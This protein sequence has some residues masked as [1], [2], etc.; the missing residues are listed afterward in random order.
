MFRA[1]SLYMLL[2]AF[3]MTPFPVEVLPG[4]AKAAAP[5]N[6][7]PDGKLIALTFDDGPKPYVLLGTR[8]GRVCP[9][10]VCS[11]CWIDK[12]SRRLSS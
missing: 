3:A 10:R 7:A 9:P 8:S 6:A 5:A 4:S 11:L 1:C 2:I 12:G